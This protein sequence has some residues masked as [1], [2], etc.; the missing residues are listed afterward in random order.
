MKAYLIDPSRRAIDP[1]EFDGTE[2][3]IRGL[4]GFPTIDSDAIRG[5]NDRLY[6]DEECFLRAT[7]D[8]ARFQLDTL[9]PV[10]GKGVIVGT[11]ATAESLGP[12]AI[13]LAD[14]SARVRF[15]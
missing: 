2:D 13:S 14:L 10:S 5:G 7:P 8:S 11:D 6:F 4:I 9:A 3:G 1:V 15:I 12:P